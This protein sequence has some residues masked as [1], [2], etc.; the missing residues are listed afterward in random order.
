MIEEY[1]CS[2]WALTVIPGGVTIDD[3]QPMSAEGAVDASECLQRPGALTPAIRACTT[4]LAQLVLIGRD[5]EG[6]AYLPYWTATVS[7]Q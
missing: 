2:H 1:E 3:E 5:G 6:A 7:S 4:E